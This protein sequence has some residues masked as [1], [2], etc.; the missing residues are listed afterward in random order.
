MGIEYNIGRIPMASCDF[1][2]RNYTY[3]DTPGDFELKNFKL[4]PEDVQ[5]KIPII[6]TAMESS[7]REIKFFGSPWSA[8]GWMKT[9]NT[10][11]GG[12]LIGDAGNKYH[13][14]WA[15][16]F[17]KFLDSYKQNGVKLWGITVENEPTAGYIPK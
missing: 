3:D 4:A 16:Y 15:Q 17:V 7:K 14:T 1:S 2:T 6:K 10:T 9:T 11:I 5:Y 8:P 13:K 12:V